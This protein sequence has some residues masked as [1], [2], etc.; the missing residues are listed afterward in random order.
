VREVG[1]F[2]L[3][4]VVDGRMVERRV[5]INGEETLGVVQG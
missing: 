1:G 4:V 2:E 5:E 3:V